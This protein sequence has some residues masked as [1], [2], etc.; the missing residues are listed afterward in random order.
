MPVEERA[1]HGARRRGA[2]SNLACEKNKHNVGMEGGEKKSVEACCGRSVRMLTAF[3]SRPLSSDST[4]ARGMAAVGRLDAL[5]R[6]LPRR[7]RVASFSSGLLRSAGVWC[8]GDRAGA[9]SR[10]NAQERGGFGIPGDQ[11]GAL[12]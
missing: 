2:H 6:V 4:D 1:Q 5:S 8:T 11:A 10:V 9:L 3:S 7:D 12:T